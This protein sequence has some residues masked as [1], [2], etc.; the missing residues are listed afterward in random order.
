[1]FLFLHI[2]MKF[3]K[4][5][6][7]DNCSGLNKINFSSFVELCEKQTICSRSGDTSDSKKKNKRI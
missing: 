2:L 7:L 5:H 6:G 4:Q 1:M 3:V